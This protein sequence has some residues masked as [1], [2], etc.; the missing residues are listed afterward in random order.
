MPTISNHPESDNKAETDSISVEIESNDNTNTNESNIW[1]EKPAEDVEK[2]REK[3]FE[4]YL[5]DLFMWTQLMFRLSN[6]FFIWCFIVNRYG[7]K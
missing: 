3:E 1:K 5:A 6:L 7:G 4:E 2:T